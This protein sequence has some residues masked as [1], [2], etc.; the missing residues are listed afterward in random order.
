MAVNYL[1]SV[2]QSVVDEINLAR[3]NP[4]AYADILAQRRQYYQGNTIK[5]P[6]QVTRLTNEGVAALDEAIR[7]LRSTSPLP[8]LNPSRGMSLAAK[9]HVNDIGP[10]GLV[11]HTGT[12]GSDPTQRVDRYGQG[13]AGENIDFGASSGREIVIDLLVDDGVSSR[14]HRENILKPSYR[15]AGVSVGPHAQY[16]TMAVIDFADQYKEASAPPTTPVPTPT[17]PPV[18][19]APPS[20]TG[21]DG[22]TLFGTAGSDTLRGG[23][24]TY[25][26]YAGKGD[27]V[28]LGSE[29]NDGSVI[30]AYGG[31]GNDILVDGFGNDILIGGKGD[32]YFIGTDGIDTFV[33]GSGSDTFSFVSDGLAI[34]PDFDPASDF[35]ELSGDLEGS[36]VLVSRNTSNSIGV[37]VS[38]NGGSS[39]D[40][41]VALLTNY[42]GDLASVSRRIIGGQGS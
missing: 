31:S 20:N 5:L 28:L 25:T 13:Y 38:T 42:T 10:K 19:I 22:K 11:T 24:G 41:N 16:G 8:A 21:S 37:F 40:L 39:F 26:L 14:G 18:P 15:F 12:D 33:G 4:N 27:D 3:T 1:S 2:E 6:G 17:P 35:I 30:Y 9:D 32:D 7:V 34:I 29:S 23:S 36:R